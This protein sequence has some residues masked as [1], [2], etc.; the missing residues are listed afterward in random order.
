[1]GSTIGVPDY[2]K[3]WA[4]WDQI[5]QRFD[6][7]DLKLQDL[8]NNWSNLDNK[9]NKVQYELSLPI[10]IPQ[11]DTINTLEQ[12]VTELQALNI[13][14]HTDDRRLYDIEHRLA[15]LEDMTPMIAEN[16]DLKLTLETS[17]RSVNQLALD[18]KDHKQTIETLER[19]LTQ[20]TNKNQY[21]EAE[22]KDLKAQL[23]QLKYTENQNTTLY[24]EN[25]DLKNENTRLRASLS[26]STIKLQQLKSL[27]TP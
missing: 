7:Q 12:K 9:V 17:Q 10:K 4:I 22:N 19:S 3:D 25:Q 6:T 20:E 14:I 5:K 2:A 24:R 27:L 8:E 1:M 23:K 11:A 18:L 13:Q 15:H 21:L 16:K 26:Q